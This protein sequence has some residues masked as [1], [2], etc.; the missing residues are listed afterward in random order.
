MES[1]VNY[2]SPSDMQRVIDAIPGLKFYNGVQPQD[3]QFFFRISYWCALRASEALSISPIKMDLEQHIIQLGRTKTRKHDW[4]V[5][6]PP[7]IPMIQLWLDD[8]HTR[9]ISD[10]MPIVDVT[11]RTVHRW[12]IK[13]GKICEIPALL[14]DDNE[15]GEKT[16]THIWRKS[17]AKD[18]LSG[19]HGPRTQVNVVAAMLRHKSPGTTNKYVRLQSDA[20]MEYWHGM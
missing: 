11:Y 2:I 9:D 6:P 15:I 4:C 13:L 5:I 17:M 10:D 19:E 1:K 8:R 3:V 12:H 7:V 18:M 16:K 14:I 20:A